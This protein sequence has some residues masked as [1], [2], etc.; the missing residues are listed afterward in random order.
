VGKTVALYFSAHWCG[1]CQAFTPKL[2]DVYNELKDR[3]EE[4]EI[5]FISSDEDQETFEEYFKSMPWLALPFGDK[6][7]NDLCSF[8]VLKASHP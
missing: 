8:S 7:N 6:T 3:A 2:A 4:F 5:V 1:P